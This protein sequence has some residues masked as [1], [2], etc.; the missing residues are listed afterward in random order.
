MGMAA[1]QA[2]FLTLTARKSN[3]EYQGQQVNQ[4]RTALANESANIYNKLANMDVPTA[5]S[6]TS[7][8]KNYYTFK[9]ADGETCSI[10]NIVV[11]ENGGANEPTKAKVQLNYKEA[12][13]YTQQYNLGSIASA[14][15]NDSNNAYT[16]LL[17]GSSK[18]NATKV[19]SV[20]QEMKDKYSAYRDTQ[21]STSSMSDTW[22]Y[23]RVEDSNDS[24][25]GKSY[26]INSEEIDKG[27]A[28]ADYTPVCYASEKTYA[29]T[30]KQ[31]DA[32][33]VKN[34]SGRYTQIEFD[35]NSNFGTDT[36]TL[37]YEYGTDEDAYEKAFADYEYK[38]AQYDQEVNVLNSKTE[39]IQNQDKRLELKLKQLDTER[40]AL[41]TEMEAVKG[42]LKKNVEGTF[43]TFG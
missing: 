24:N 6:K 30:T 19:S 22:Y 39:V 36:I 20:P 11:T 15:Y 40:S 16:S 7:Y 13:T 32:T 31:V 10:S 2:R 28:N 21:N 12:T 5:P 23:I 9:M 42:Y 37:G 3:T 27:N 8:N 1:S 41:D 43:N 17:V 18:Y 25:Y 38:K 34:D 33:L 4:Q 14:S 35:S 29:E 26:Y